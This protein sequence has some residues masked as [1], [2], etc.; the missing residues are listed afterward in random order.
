MSRI[1]TH[2]TTV[3]ALVVGGLVALA[4]PM[5]AAVAL[6]SPPVGAGVEVRSPAQLLARGAA[7][8]VTVAYTCPQGNFAR[9]DV[10]LT[11]RSGP[12]VVS[13][14]WSREVTCTGSE[15]TVQVVVTAST[16]SRTFKKGPAVATA[17]LFTCGFPFCGTVSDSREIAVTR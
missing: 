3:L 5:S 15:E 8:E 6:Q 13:G 7:V 9:L 1:R 17:E 12:T 14:S 10:S 16:G 11:Q 4:V 2:H